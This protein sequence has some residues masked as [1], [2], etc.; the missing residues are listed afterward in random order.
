LPRAGG[1]TDS[2]EED[3]DDEDSDEEEIPELIPVSKTAPK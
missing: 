2:D 3:E 1:V